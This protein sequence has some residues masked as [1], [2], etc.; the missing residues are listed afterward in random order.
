[1]TNPVPYVL[2]ATDH[3]AAVDL[4]GITDSQRPVTKL[5][6]N[7]AW[8]IAPVTRRGCGVCSHRVRLVSAMVSLRAPR[9]VRRVPERPPET[10]WRQYCARAAP[11]WRRSAAAA[12]WVPTDG[13]GRGEPAAA[14]RRAARKPA[15]RPPVDHDGTNTGTFELFGI[16][17]TGRPVTMTG[18]EIFSAE[19]GKFAKS[20]TRRTPRACCASSGSSR[21]HSSCG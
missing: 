16:P 7:P 20:G 11:R 21:H 14:S 4:I 13:R 17:P 10:D 19:G 5:L 3:H 1:M 6:S 15:R 18:Q 2:L 8:L 9:G 12:V